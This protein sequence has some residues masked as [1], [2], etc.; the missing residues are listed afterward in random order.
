MLV[1]KIWTGRRLAEFAVITMGQSPPGN[2]VVSAA[3][4]PQGLP[5]LNG[6]TEFGPHHPTPVQ[7]TTTIHKRAY[8]G[9]VLLCVRGSTGR[10]NWADQEY[11]I[12]RGIA[13]IRHRANEALQPFVRAVIEFGLPGLL[14]EATGSVFSNVSSS[15]LGAL[16]YPNLAETEQLAIAHILGT[17]D[18]KMEL[19]RGMNETLESMAR[20]LFQSWFVDFDPVHAKAALKHH[21]ANPI[22]R[23]G[24]STRATEATPSDHSPLEE[25]S[26]RQG[27]QPAG[28]PE[29]GIRR[30]YSAR[31]LQRAQTLRDNRTDAEGLLWQYLRNKQLGGYKFRR[32][33]PMGPYIADFACL[34][35]KLLVELDGG[36]H[37]A[38]QAHDGRRDAFL[39]EKGYRILRFW[40]NEVFDNCFGV[41]E[42]VYAALT[43]PPPQQ[44]VSGG[45]AVAASAQE[46][47]H[48]TVERARAYLDGM[49]PEIAALFPDR[50]VSSESGRMIPEGWAVSLLG[51]GIEILSGGTPKT[52]VA[53]YWDGDIPWY[54][55]R[56][57]PAPSD[58]FVLDTERK[59][60]E[61]GVA[62]SAAKLLP[63]GTTIITARGTVGRL[64][65]LGSPMSMNQTC[66]GI[67]GVQG[68]PDFFTYLRIRTAVDDLQRRTHGTI[69]DTITR[70]SFSLI[71]TVIPPSRV[72]EAFEIVIE[73]TMRRILSNL[74]ESRALA[75]M[76]DTL[77][78]EL[79]SGRIRIPEPEQPGS[80]GRRGGRASRRSV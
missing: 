78:P 31:T 40:N 29:G 21:A 37:A 4:V 25:E 20:G 39:R 24:D 60:T 56:D 50:F 38:R 49:E 51:D 76:R 79:V 19:N 26:A 73:P 59:I 7:S 28:E 58:V 35:E 46:G 16:P 52:S 45:L 41:L 18:D 15:Q 54:T 55:A 68:Y 8:P 69:F 9:D 77:L 30:R 14:A 6:P 22:P 74:K 11:A 44:P 53:D 23:R 71:D 43:D 62:H 3:G 70:Q 61:T 13:A 48:W 2:T 64:A 33:Q 80:S 75:S 57:A 67:R 66:Y 42:R 72:A 27:R 65:C 1:E 34:P 47:T 32:Q 36:Q 17:L 5:L 10:M 12:G 63:T